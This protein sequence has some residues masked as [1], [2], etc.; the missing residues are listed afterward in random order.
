MLLPI[1]GL[2]ALSGCGG[3]G[4]GGAPDF[5]GST[6]PGKFLVTKLVADTAGKAAKVD[7]NLVNP[8]GIAFTPSGPFW[9]A[10][11][12]KGAVTSY[13]SAG[14]TQPT[15]VH[16]PT[17][18]GGTGGPVSGMTYN[19]TSDFAITGQGPA[20]FVFA[21]EDGVISAWK[22]GGNAV[23]VA[24]RSSVGAV[25]KGVAMA[26]VSGVNFLY[27]TDFHN[28]KVDVFDKNFVFLRSFTDK[29]VPAGYAP[30]GIRSING[31]LVVTF[32]L[33]KGPD[34]HDDQAGPGNGYV[35]IFTPGG[36]MTER[37]ASRGPLN[38]PWGIA[39]APASFGSASQE[40]LIGNFGDGRINAYNPNTARFLG[41]LYDS[42]GAPMVITGL[43]G[44]SFGNGG[45]A[46]S[47]STLF[48]TAG[49][50]AESNG[51][52]GSIAVQ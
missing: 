52:F 4:G 32:A 35:D 33:Q 28:G 42:T 39:L 22:S 44:L 20:T 19:G 14:V 29:T 46:G 5:G 8:W 49:P 38:S 18:T 47:V 23:T 11:N 24:N 51:L 15:V 7:A 40:L 31:S 43:W 48:F 37:V 9:V 45:T 30:F 1:V 13:D 6:R 10:D 21:S 26:A 12:G 34:N 25:Y 41:N 27:A 17:S 36:V 16:I 50:N 3:G 2:V